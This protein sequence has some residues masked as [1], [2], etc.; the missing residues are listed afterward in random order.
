MCT[1]ETA[2]TSGAVSCSGQFN[3]DREPPAEWIAQLREISPV[4]EDRGW[5]ELVWESGDPWAPVQRWEL[6]EM[7]HASV[8]DPGEVRELRGPHPRKEGHPCTSTPLSS[9]AVHPAA[10]YRPCICRRKTNA[11]RG[12][13]SLVS[14]TEWK[15][16][17]RTG[18]VG[19]P[20]WIIQ[21]TT[22]GHKC[23]FG[24]DE[25]MLLEAEG[26]PTVAP[27]SGTLAYAPFDGRVVRSIT[28]FNRLWQF[29]N[30]IDEYRE[31]MG[32]GY[33][34]YK[35]TVDQELRRQLVEHLKTQ[36]EDVAD[37]FVKA[38]NAGEMD[39]LPRTSID[40]DR[41]APQNDAHFIETG[42]MLHHSRA[43]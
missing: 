34:Q 15:L 30:N 9:W 6:Y 22:G 39:H 25:Q 10:N 33:T 32:P 5:L 2:S 20:F 7:I 18:Y 12:G 26:Y 38:A 28:R 31:A 35:K 13:V 41:L 11:W 29:K 24:H 3:Y 43:H 1:T 40:Y 36:M 16:F 14:L 42:N 23:A 21:G 27:P 4:C 37:L 8:V 17:Q 19:R